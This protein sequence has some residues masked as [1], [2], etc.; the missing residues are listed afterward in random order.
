MCLCKCLLYGCRLFLYRGSLCYGQEVCNNAGALLILLSYKR[1]QTTCFRIFIV[2]F[3][4]VVVYF[5][6]IPYSQHFIIVFYNCL[7]VCFVTLFMLILKA[8]RAYIILYKFINEFRH[9]LF[10]GQYITVLYAFTAALTYQHIGVHMG[11]QAIFILQIMLLCMLH[12]P[13]LQ[14]YFLCLYHTVRFVY[15]FSTAYLDTAGVLLFCHTTIILFNKFGSIFMSVP[16]IQFEYF[17]LFIRKYVLLVYCVAFLYVLFIYYSFIGINGFS[18]GNVYIFLVLIFHFIACILFV[19]LQLFT[20]QYIH[21]TAGVGDL[22]IISCYTVFFCYMLYPHC[23]EPYM[24]LWSFILYRPTCFLTIRAGKLV[25]AY[26]LQEG[27]TFLYRI[28]FNVF[29]GFWKVFLFSLYADFISFTFYFT[30]AAQHLATCFYVTRHIVTKAVYNIKSLIFVCNTRCN[31]GRIHTDIN[32][33]PILCHIITMGFPFMCSAFTTIQPD[34]FFRKLFLDICLQQ[35]GLHYCICT[36]INFFVFYQILYKV[37][38]PSFSCRGAIL[39]VML[40]PF[41]LFPVQED[42]NIPAK[43]LYNIIRSI[44]YVCVQAYIIFCRFEHPH[45]NGKRGSKVFVQAAIVLFTNRFYLIQ[46]MYVHRLGCGGYPEKCFYLYVVSFIPVQ[47]SSYFAVQCAIRYPGLYIF[48]ED[49]SK[50][51]EPYG[52]LFCNTIITVLF[53]QILAQLDGFTYFHLCLYNKRTDSFILPHTTFII[54][55][56]LR[57]RQFFKE[58]GLMDLY[59]LCHHLVHVC[60]HKIICTGKAAHAKAMFIVM[61]TMLLHFVSG[62]S[63]NYGIVLIMHTLTNFAVSWTCTFIQYYIFMYTEEAMF[64]TYCSCE[65]YYLFKFTLLYTIAGTRCCFFYICADTRYTRR[66]KGGCY[67]GITLFRGCT[68]LKHICKLLIIHFITHATFFMRPYVAKILYTFVVL[69]VNKGI[70]MFG[71]IFYHFGCTGFGL[72]VIYYCVRIQYV[73]QGVFM[74]SLFI[75]PDTICY[76]N[77]FTRYVV[78][79]WYRI[80]LVQYVH[81]VVIYHV[82]DVIH[83]VIVIVIVIDILIDIV[84]TICLIYREV[85]VKFYALRQ[86]PKHHFVETLLLKGLCRL[87]LPKVITACKNSTKIIIFI[88]HHEVFL[89]GFERIFILYGFSLGV[90]AKKLACFL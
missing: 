86:K 14:V 39:H 47:I 77:L 22:V 44:S 63:Y 59:A 65:F 85:D 79:I 25:F 54:Y 58:N 20:R 10:I 75:Y 36:D 74:F 29:N 78:V 38:Y 15:C 72:I 18:C 34:F 28:H 26:G 50:C 3:T 55:M 40:G 4:L 81:V 45:T 57:I 7:W 32:E 61:A 8:V 62:V 35:P 19:C 51:H 56:F 12:G 64:F 31:R 11:L 43:T 1:N 16:C 67:M 70:Y 30:H 69:G 42:T 88:S 17:I 90:T 23:F 2:L 37:I 84:I 46:N 5:T 24:V 73:M 6:T 87:P 48:C 66:F 80:R 13:L 89:Y 52:L 41:I 68:G 27:V 71:K 83:I 9:Q 76:Q 33:P 21:L 53:L 49:L 60:F 82:K